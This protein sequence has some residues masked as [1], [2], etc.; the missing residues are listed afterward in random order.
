MKPIS[1]TVSDA[2]AGAKSSNPIIMDY[3][4]RPEVS[5]QVVVSG[6]A[7]W[8]VEQTLDN[9]NA[10]GVTP[11]WFSHPDSDMVTQTVNRQGNYAFIPVSVRLTLNSG[12]GSATLTVVQA[13][14]QG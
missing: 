4:G 5:L 3:H 12:T 2:S 6:T 1:V 7:N 11:T 8:T 10:A 14:L 9:P 13:G